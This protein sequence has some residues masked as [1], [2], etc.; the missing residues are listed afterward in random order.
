MAMGP[1]PTN[2]HANALVGSDE[3]TKQIKLVGN[4]VFDGKRFAAL[5]R[6]P[7]NQAPRLDVN[8]PML[9]D[10]GSLTRTTSIADGTSTPK[11]GK[12]ASLST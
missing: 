4:G 2:G 12:G 1:T 10:L 7:R 9:Q 6:S 3:N 11:A 5:Q 8:A